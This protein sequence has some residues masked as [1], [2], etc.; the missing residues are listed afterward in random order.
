MNL[1]SMLF[2]TVLVATL[3]SDGCSGDPPTGILTGEVSFDGQLLRSGSINFVDAQGRVTSTGISPEGKYRVSKVPCGMVRIAVF[4]DPHVP[5]KMRPLGK[6][7]Q[8]IVLPARYGK[9]TE[10]DLVVEVTG[11][12]QQFDIVMKP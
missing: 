11:G 3:T 1:R 9:S 4:S 10:S 2:V 7:D 8:P 5:E 6:S 12:A